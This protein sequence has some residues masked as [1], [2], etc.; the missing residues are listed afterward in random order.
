M[1]KTEIQ[2]SGDKRLPN[3]SIVVP[4]YN[5]AA[6]IEQCLESLCRIAYPAELLEII[7][8]DNDSKDDTRR[9]LDRFAD[10]VRVFHHV[11]R[12][13]AEGIPCK[14]PALSGNTFRGAVQTS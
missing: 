3:V 10:R 4:V 13:A 1:T 2:P 12:G 5:G 9:L 7:A 14:T 6:T 8:V 11:R